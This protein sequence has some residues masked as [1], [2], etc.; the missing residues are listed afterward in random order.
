LLAQPEKVC[1]LTHDWLRAFPNKVKE[2]EL[3]AEIR[4]TAA[5]AWNKRRQNQISED[6]K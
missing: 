4:V 6:L 2:G 5:V 3:S 1:Y